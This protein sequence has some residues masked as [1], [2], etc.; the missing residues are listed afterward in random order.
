M[1]PVTMDPS[2]SRTY[3]SSRPAAFAISSLEEGGKP[4]IVSNRPVWPMLHIS[5]RNELLSSPSIL[6]AKA[7][8][9][10]LVQFI[11]GHRSPI[12]E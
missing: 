4:A 9:F 3:R 12:D 8:A 10:C 2:H 11:S 1:P 6:P 5:L 7:S